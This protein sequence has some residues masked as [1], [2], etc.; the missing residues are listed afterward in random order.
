[1]YKKTHFAESICIGRE[2]QKCKT[3]FW[4]LKLYLNL[5]L[6][7]MNAFLPF[8][9]GKG[10]AAFTDHIL[11]IYLYFWSYYFVVESLKQKM[12]HP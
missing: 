7:F 12:E 5:C 1:M 10:K 4:L 2:L 8:Y 11:E 3:Y 9:L 6:S